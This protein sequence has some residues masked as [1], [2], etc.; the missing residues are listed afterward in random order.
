MRRFFYKRRKEYR[1]FIYGL[2]AGLALALILMSDLSRLLDAFY[3]QR[4]ENKALAAWSRRATAVSYAQCRRNAAS[5]LNKIVVWPISHLSEGNSY[6]E[7]PSQPILWSNESQVPVSS[8]ASRPFLAVAV[9]HG[10]H[11]RSIELV[12]V[13]SPAAVHGGTTWK[14]K[15]G[16]NR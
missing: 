14:E 12:F 1:V 15:F 7:N 5:C 4:V 16:L 11:P 13:G 9:I 3:E 8:V 10:V 2:G 6:V